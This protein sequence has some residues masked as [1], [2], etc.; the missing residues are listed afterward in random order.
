MPDAIAEKQPEIEVERTA[1]KPVVKKEQNFH[2][3]WAVVSLLLSLFGFIVP[4]IFSTLGIIFAIG[5]L[6][7]TN[8]ENMKGKWMAILAILFGITSIVVY[9]ILVIAGINFAQ[10]MLAQF[11]DPSMFL[12]LE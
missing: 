6:M 1:V 4:F 9:T 7:Q 5:G 12:G 11:G 3:E 10:E 8:R 2:S